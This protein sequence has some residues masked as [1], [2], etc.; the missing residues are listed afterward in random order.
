MH[1]WIDFIDGYAPCHGL[2]VQLELFD[3]SEI[4]QY[5]TGA[6]SI[7]IPRTAQVG[8]GVMSSVHTRPQVRV[9]ICVHTAPAV[10]KEHGDTNR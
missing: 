8:T 10:S 4:I 9:D 2:V 6:M 1:E 3:F 7:R 5:G